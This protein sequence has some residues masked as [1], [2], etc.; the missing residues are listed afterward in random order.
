MYQ[1]KR[2]YSD[3]LPNVLLGVQRPI[4]LALLATAKLQTHILD[5]EAGIYVKYHRHVTHIKLK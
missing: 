2:K 3:K 4:E 1:T 5:S